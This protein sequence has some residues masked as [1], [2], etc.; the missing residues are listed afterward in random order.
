VA[1]G[2]AVLPVCGGQYPASVYRQGIASAAL[3]RRVEKVVGYSCSPT[4]SRASPWFKK[5]S[6]RITLPF[7][8]VITPAYFS[9]SGTP[10]A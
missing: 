6:T 3:S 10:L 8:S 9:A 4:A 5:S 1:D 2:D 7:L